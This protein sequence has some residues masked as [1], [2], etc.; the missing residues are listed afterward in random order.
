MI[1]PILRFPFKVEKHD[2][3][4]IV[5]GKKIRLYSEMDPAKIPW[6]ESGVT[7]VMECTGKFLTTEKC[8][9]HYERRS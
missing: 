1:Q 8:E 2:Q 9:A 3:G 5:N 4:V 6:G 7:S